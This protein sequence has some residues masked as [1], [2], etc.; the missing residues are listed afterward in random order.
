MRESFQFAKVTVR[1]CNDFQW[2]PFISCWFFSV[3][4]TWV[5]PDFWACSCCHFERRS[6]SRGRSSMLLWIGGRGHHYDLVTWTT[7]RCQNSVLW[8]NICYFSTTPLSTHSD[9]SLTVSL[10]SLSIVN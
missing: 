4:L 5:L 6:V 9:W 8:L 1:C 7:V 3:N 2:L 10:F